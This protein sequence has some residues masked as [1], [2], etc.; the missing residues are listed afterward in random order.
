MWS[1]SRLTS[2]VI[3]ESMSFFCFLAIKFKAPSKQAEYP[4]ANSCSGL[5]PS[6]LLFGEGFTRVKSIIPSSDLTRPSRP[7]TAVALDV[8]S[9]SDIRSPHRLFY[10]ISLQTI[11]KVAIKFIL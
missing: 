2:A 8:N 3:D 6:S 5:V 4:A 10:V 7:P 9:T 1:F 11:K